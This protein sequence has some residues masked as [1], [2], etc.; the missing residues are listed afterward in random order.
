MIESQFSSEKHLVKN[1]FICPEILRIDL[2][3]GTWKAMTCLPTNLCKMPVK[4][5]YEIIGVEMNIY[6]IPLDIGLY[7]IFPL[8]MASGLRPI[9]EGYLM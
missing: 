1:C 4:L 6:I 7:T 2:L 9:F 8:Y 3:I 5:A